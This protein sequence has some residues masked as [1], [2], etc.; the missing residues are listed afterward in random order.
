M[1]VFYCQTLDPNYLQSC[2][3]L[4]SRAITVMHCDYR[5]VSV[6]GALYL[7]GKSSHVIPGSDILYSAVHISLDCH[8][9]QVSCGTWHIACVTGI[10]GKI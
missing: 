1:Y 5:F 8:V 3:V 9:K 2:I 7:W 4:C 10:P 6:E